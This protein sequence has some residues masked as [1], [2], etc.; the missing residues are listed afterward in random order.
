MRLY[1]KK[2]K[3]AQQASP[4]K[5]SKRRR[6][7]KDKSRNVNIIAQLQNTKGNQTV[8]RLLRIA[9]NSVD[10]DSLIHSSTALT[11]FRD[12]PIYPGVRGRIQPKLKVSSTKDRYEQDADR[13][14]DDVL[15]QQAPEMGKGVEGNIL[16]TKAGSNQ[17]TKLSSNFQNRVFALQGG[18]QPLA[19]SE[20]AF[21][22][23]RFSSDFSQV[24]IHTDSQAAKA[25]RVIN[26]HAFTLGRDIVFGGGEY[27]PGTSEGNRLLAHELVHVVQQRNT[28]NNGMH[29]AETVQR[30]AITQM[31]ITPDYARA[32]SDGDLDE[33]IQTLIDQ[34]QSIE[35]EPMSAPAQEG[36][37]VFQPGSEAEFEAARANLAILQ[38]E[39]RRRIAERH[40]RN[41]A[42][43]RMTITPQS[44]SGLS[45]EDLREQIRMLTEQIQGLE[46]LRMTPLE[47]LELP[48][49]EQAEYETARANLAI[50]QAERHERNRDVTQIAI[51]SLYATRLPDEDLE[52][53]LSILA[54]Q[55]QCLEELR[56]S[57]VEGEAFPLQNE[58]EYEIARSN[59]MILNEERR[60]RRAEGR[61]RRI[62]EADWGSFARPGDI[63]V[64]VSLEDRVV[65]IMETLVDRY[66]YPVDGA[67]ALVGNLWVE[68]G[69]TFAPNI[70]EG[71]RLAQTGE[72][73]PQR[74]G[75]GLAQWTG[76][77]RRAVLGTEQG[78]DILF[79]MDAQ[80]SYMVREL[81]TTHAGVNNVLNNPPS[82]QLATRRVF[83]DYETPQPV[84][85][86]R[87]AVHAGN[88]A[89]IQRT[90]RRMNGFERARTNRAIRARSMYL[91]E[92]T[93]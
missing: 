83:R 16:Q 20:R 79:D 81:Q 69:G 42:V 41:L 19:L 17:P 73:A 80:I 52:E 44:A 9:K 66:N 14:A 62:R 60:R 46:Q 55:L 76:V 93:E 28:S 8:Q 26:A 50:L 36:E 53:Q 23:P 47:C 30:D 57:S 32:L 64:A 45:D 6:T 77:R 89:E 56:V 13:I 85:D 39:R 40:R 43:T 4:V 78:V 84:V 88:A 61:R 63:D 10:A 2:S 54:E 33:Q 75:V 12:L 3:V 70:L 34:V 15:R 37:E 92:S 29:S 59:Y 90:E 5:S 72:A 21:F 49:E 74:G 58:E 11:E 25:A 68:S 22:E 65:Y 31:S 7:F 51:T 82:L 87:R 18:G 48:I 27:R 67:A 86:W 71:G 1:E 38:A 91:R 24:R 35:P